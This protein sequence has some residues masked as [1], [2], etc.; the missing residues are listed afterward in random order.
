MHGNF[1]ISKFSNPQIYLYNSFGRR[2]IIA[3][4]VSFYGHAYSFCKCLKYS[5]NLMV[6]VFAMTG[7]IQVTARSIRER[8]KEMKK[9][10]RWH[11]TEFLSLKMCIPHDPVSSPEIQKYLRISVIHRQGEP[12]SLHASFICQGFRH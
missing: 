1:Q 12:I 10:F 2:Q 8:F 11:V 6:F 3:K 4:W 9:H 5:L 7:N